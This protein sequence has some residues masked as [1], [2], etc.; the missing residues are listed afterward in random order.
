MHGFK[1]STGCLGSEAQTMIGVH[2]S[3]L[4]CVRGGEDGGASKN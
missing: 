4:A 3:Q 2:P 1:T